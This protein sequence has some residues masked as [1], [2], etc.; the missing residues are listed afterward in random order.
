[1]DFDHSANC[2]WR[3]FGKPCSC[4]AP[5]RAA[6]EQ[7]SIA[8]MTESGVMPLASELAEEEAVTEVAASAQVSDDLNAV[9]NE[10]VSKLVSAGLTEDEAQVV[11]KRRILG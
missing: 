9:I 7:R 1:M 10:A 2:H 6:D 5:Q 4:D 3:L 11:I 8:R